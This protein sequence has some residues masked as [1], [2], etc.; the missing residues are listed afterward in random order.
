MQ[1]NAEISRREVLERLCCVLA[2]AAWARWSEVAARSAEQCTVRYRA[3]VLPSGV[4]A[5]V[6]T[7]TATGAANTHFFTA[8]EKE[9]VATVVDLII[10][11]DEVSPGARAARVHEWIDFVIANSPADVQQQWREGL[12]NLDRLSL[13]GSGQKFQQLAQENQSKLLQHLA[14]REYA[15]TTPAERFFAL[16]KE[17]TVNGYYTSEIGLMKDLRY[18]G[19]TFTEAPD[20]QCHGRGEQKPAGRKR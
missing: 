5:P 4:K 20:S 16:A 18:A 1:L 15:P 2:T 11:T 6:P 10:P 13:E 9:L 7:I 12:A 14:E 3:E 17:A 19:G 8:E